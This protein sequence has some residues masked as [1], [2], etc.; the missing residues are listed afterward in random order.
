M[1]VDHRFLNRPTWKLPWFGLI[2]A[3]AQ[4]ALQHNA[5]GKGSSPIGH[6][7][8]DGG[9]PGACG[10]AL[11]CSGVLAVLLAPRATAAHRTARGWYLSADVTV[12]LCRNDQSR[13]RR[14]DIDAGRG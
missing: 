2:I 10:I 5:K 1:T 3:R 9:R 7:R 4:A 6:F 8:C 13:A 12:Q 11:G 14:L